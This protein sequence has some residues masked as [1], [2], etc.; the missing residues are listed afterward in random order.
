[1]TNSG[2]GLPLRQWIWLSTATASFAPVMVEMRGETATGQ[3]TI[4]ESVEP[5]RGVVRLL[6]ASTTADPEGA[7]GSH[8]Q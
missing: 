7:F 5:G 8:V 4:A 3:P 2:D 6:P 1:M